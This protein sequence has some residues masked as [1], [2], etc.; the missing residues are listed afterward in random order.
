MLLILKARESAPKRGYFYRSWVTIESLVAMA[1]ELDLH[2]H[3]E[4]HQMGK[5]CDSNPSECSTK[6]R[7]WHTL[8]VLEIM[9]GAPQGMASPFSYQERSAFC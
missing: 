1:K 7:V 3:A 9:I 5:H 8:F 4:I 6:T 2:E